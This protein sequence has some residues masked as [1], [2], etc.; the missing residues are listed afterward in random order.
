MLFHHGQMKKTFL[1][2]FS[3]VEDNSFLYY[4]VHWEAYL[5]FHNG[6]FKPRPTHCPI[7]WLLAS[8]PRNAPI[9]RLH[10]P[11]LL[12]VF[13]N[14]LQWSIRVS[15]THWINRGGVR[16]RYIGCRRWWIGIVGGDAIRCAV[17]GGVETGVRCEAEAW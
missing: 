8:T 16:G 6:L 17:G 10:H 2:W 13:W 12:A 15:Q 9:R 7:P 1:L 3:A 5:V 11:L 14:L 4:Q